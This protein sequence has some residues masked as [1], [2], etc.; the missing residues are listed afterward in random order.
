MLAYMCGPDQLAHLRPAERLLAEAVARGDVASLPELLAGVGDV[1]AVCDSDG[2][3]MVERACLQALQDGEEV[4]VR[5]CQRGA[6]P[7]LAD[8][9]GRTPLQLAE[10][11][12]EQGPELRLLLPPGSPLKS[13]Y[14]ACVRLLRAACATSSAPLSRAAKAAE[15]CG[16][17]SATQD[18]KRCARCE[19]RW[20]C[21]SSCQRSDWKAHKL[22][23]NATRDVRQLLEAAADPG[24]P[25]AARVELAMRAGGEQ[26]LAGERELRELAVEVKAERA[27][28]RARACRARA[29]RALATTRACAPSRAA[30]CHRVTQQDPHPCIECR[31]LDAILP[32]HRV[33]SSI[34]GDAVV[35]QADAVKQRVRLACLRLLTGLSSQENKWVGL[36]A[37]IAREGG[38]P[39]ARLMLRLTAERTTA[40]REALRLIH[41][42]CCGP[43]RAAHGGG[44]AAAGRGP[45]TD[46]LLAD[47]AALRTLA[48]SLY[49]TEHGI[50]QA[51]DRHVAMELFVTLAYDRSSF[52]RLVSD[53]WLD[54]RL[55]AVFVRGLF[56]V[57]HDGSGTVLEWLFLAL[58][59]RPSYLA[60]RASALLP[61]LRQLLE[62]E[63]ETLTA[64]EV[65]QQLG[66]TLLTMA[67][68]EGMGWED[69]EP[70]A[71]ENYRF[72]TERRHRKAA[73][74][75]HAAVRDLRQPA[76]EAFVREQGSE[77]FLVA[78]ALNDAP[79]SVVLAQAAAAARAPYDPAADATWAAKLAA[80]EAAAARGGPVTAL[81]A[82]AEAWRAAREGRL[83]GAMP[84]A[85]RRRGR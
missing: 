26:A 1:A 31:A 64:E 77:F 8:S 30:A 27:V 51:S 5:M 68:P 53:P 14:P 10:G 80:A 6:N 54:A 73:L 72:T 32:S 49:T 57:G 66:P 34:P 29:A 24:A 78:V 85:P 16:G 35:Y 71:A 45:V 56:C 69:A 15:G 76:L 36:H 67:M 63:G 83:E 44:D 38:L 23:C 19:L 37:A 41:P 7:L 18:L 48:Q 75:L 33:P 39:V 4:A 58:E 3:G 65:V 25:A 82:T 42:V 28:E 21:S 79:G 13:D 9:L 81:L 17:C 22:R 11:A 70:D 59:H 84:R 55:L 74:L 47:A 12:E 60:E 50:T 2:V 62:G 52:E 61:A 43:P 40:N 46:A 20:Y